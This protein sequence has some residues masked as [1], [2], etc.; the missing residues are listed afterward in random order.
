MAIAIG[1]RSAHSTFCSYVCLWGGTSDSCNATHKRNETKW[2]ETKPERLQGAQSSH[3]ELHK[4]PHITFTAIKTQRTSLT[5]HSSALLWSVCCGSI[6]IQSEAKQTKAKQSQ[7]TSL[8][9]LLH[10][11]RRSALSGFGYK[12]VQ[13]PKR[14]RNAKMSNV[15]KIGKKQNNNN[16]RADETKS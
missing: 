1:N 11:P 2:N 8:H 3:G 9:I 10:S 15:I 4:T 6:P 16:R 5:P 12:F 13:R 14:E 7:F